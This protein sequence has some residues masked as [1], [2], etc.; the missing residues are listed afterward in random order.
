MMEAARQ[1]TRQEELARK[2][3]WAS[4]GGKAERLTPEQQAKKVEENRK[5][6]AANQV[7]YGRQETAK[8]PVS[9]QMLMGKERTSDILSGAPIRSI[10]DQPVAPAPSAAPAPTQPVVTSQPR[11]AEAPT[12]REP[13]GLLEFAMNP[14]GRPTP[15]PLES[16]QRGFDMQ[17]LA[18]RADPS[19]REPVREQHRQLQLRALPY[20]FPVGL[21][22]WYGADQIGNAISNMFNSPTNR[23]LR[24]GG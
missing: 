12:F 3:G 8:T 6:A 22:R 24:Y 14:K 13:E 5:L 19:I 20:T 11:T 16:T 15:N 9:A 17:E 4:R 21:A 18:Y 23:L 2:E 1:R 10:L 7:R